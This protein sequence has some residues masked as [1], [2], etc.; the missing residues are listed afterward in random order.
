VNLPGFLILKNYIQI[1]G[2]EDFNFSNTKDASFTIWWESAVLTLKLS[3]IVA[4]FWISLFRCWFSNSA[5]CSIAVAAV[6]SVNLLTSHVN[7]EFSASNSAILSVKF[8]AGPVKRLFWRW[9]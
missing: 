9:H 1:E 3:A 2:S 6:V 4:H 8:A 5:V 7:L